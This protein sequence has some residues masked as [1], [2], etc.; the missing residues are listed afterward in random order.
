MHL[1]VI[2][3]RLCAEEQQNSTFYTAMITRSIMYYV[4]QV[5]P[6]QKKRKDKDGETR[7]A[8]EPVH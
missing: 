4:R 8:A 5:T 1:Y 6:M 3:L 2:C 7:Q